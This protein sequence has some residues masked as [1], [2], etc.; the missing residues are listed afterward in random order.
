MSN[1]EKMKPII[2][3]LRKYIKSIE[4]FYLGKGLTDADDNVN[5]LYADI[6]SE[7]DLSKYSKIDD[8][9][10]S[11]NFK[12]FIEK[13]N[14]ANFKQGVIP[15]SIITE[16]VYTETK[17]DKELYD[18]FVDKLT[19]D[20]KNYSKVNQDID[21]ETERAILKIKEHIRLSIIQNRYIKDNLRNTF[22]KTYDKY[23]NLDDK[24]TEVE[25]D[26][27]KYTEKQKEL[28]KELQEVTNKLVVKFI[29]ILGIFAAMIMGAIGSFQG[30]TSM[31][32]NAESLP[33][34][35][36]LIISSVGASGVSLILFLLLYSL[37]KLTSFKFSNCNC[38]KRSGGI[39]SIKD[40]IKDSLFGKREIECNC[41]LFNKYPTIFLLHYV[42][43][44][45]AVTGFVFMYFNFRN[46]FEMNTFYHVCIIILIY[47]LSTVLL[48]L[49]HKYII[50][51]SYATQKKHQRSY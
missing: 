18:I 27:N 15:Y 13:I 19:E 14:D 5:K 21:P 3:S 30:F 48:W 2:D 34:G 31:F 4:E 33:I 17:F 29:T 25:S 36:I 8:D 47:G 35:K 39:L 24:L 28:G 20:W 11:E 49:V 42:Y 26:L 40:T 1:S 6:N 38:Q 16:L 43:Y 23:E 32:V 50:N 9:H 10:K 37:A 7:E 22:K 41:S 44:Y 45:V 12:N 46:Y 51:R